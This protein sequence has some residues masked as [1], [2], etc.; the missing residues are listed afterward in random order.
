MLESSYLV[1]DSIIVAQML[2]VCLKLNIRCVSAYAFSIEN[3]KRPE[4]EVK[5]LMKLAEEKLLELCQHG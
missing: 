4:E 1:I 3:F 2:E 5:A